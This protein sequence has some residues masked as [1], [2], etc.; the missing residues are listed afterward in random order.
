MQGTQNLCRVRVLVLTPFGRVFL[1]KGVN[2]ITLEA[3]IGD[4][5]NPSIDRKTVTMLHLH[6]WVLGRQ[7]PLNY[8]FSQRKTASEEGKR[9]W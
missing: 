5:E 9:Q 6:T 2:S 3:C 1:L 8:T 4:G 7:R